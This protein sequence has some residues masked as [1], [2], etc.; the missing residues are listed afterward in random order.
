MG[1]GGEARRFEPGIGAHLGKRL[2]VGDQL[3]VQAG[4]RCRVA[5]GKSAAG[6]GG[7]VEDA[8]L[9]PGDDGVGRQLGRI[10]R[11]VSAG[12][13]D[14]EHDL[15]AARDSE[16]DDQMRLSESRQ[17]DDHRGIAGKGGAIGFRVAQQRRNQGA[18]ADPDGTAP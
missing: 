2:G 9:Q 3:A 8:A 4:Q 1:A 6:I 12:A 13:D 18:K 10:S 14:A 5:A 11:L 15:G 17:P 7:K 16:I